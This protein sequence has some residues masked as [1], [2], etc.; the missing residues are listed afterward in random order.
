MEKRTI[1]SQTCLWRRSRDAP[2]RSSYFEDG[3][4]EIG[5]N[6]VSDEELRK[7]QKDPERYSHIMVRVFGFSTQFISL[8][9][10]LQEYVIEKTKQMQ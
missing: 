7:A 3:G 8:S 6:I 4:M 2:R 1:L 10:Q 9:R 5:L